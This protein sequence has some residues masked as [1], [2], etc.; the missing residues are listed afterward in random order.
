MGGYA[1][2]IDDD[3][4][5]QGIPVPMRDATTVLPS[6]P[7]V[8]MRNAKPI[9]TI[10]DQYAPIQP[11]PGSR[12]QPKPIPVDAPPMSPTEQSGVSMTMRAPN[13]GAE[14]E[15][16]I[17]AP[18]GRP[19][20]VGRVSGIE[21]TIDPSSGQYNTPDPTKPAVAS[22][23]SK[24][25]N[26]HNPILRVLGEIGA[27]T[28]RAL[29][30]V[31]T[32]VAPGVAAAI[33]GSTV[34]K[35]VEMARDEAQQ[36]REAKRA[37]EEATT[38]H[39]QAETGDA[40][41][42]TELTRRQ[43]DVVGDPKQGLTPEEVTIH[44][45]MTGEKGQPRINPQ[46]QQPYSYL[47]A[48][49]AVQQ[50]KQDS[51]PDKAV[52]PD[53]PEQQYID[54]YQ[55]LHPGAT[56]AEALKTYSAITQKPE[57]EP[58]QLMVVPGAAPNT[59]QV[60][61]VKPGMTISNQAA[62]PGEAATASRA[63][64]R[65]HDKA[66]VQPAE[67]VEKSYQMMNNAYQEYEAARKLGKDLPTGA[68][69]MVALSTHLATTFGNVKGARVTKDMIEEHLG[70]R[71]VSDSALVAMQKFT[72]GDALSPDQ[73]KAFHDLIAQ[74]RKLSWQTAAKE[75]DRKNIPID[76]LPP[77]LQNVAHQPGGA[78]TAPQG[79]SDEVYK[80]G[81]LIGH[82]VDHKFVGLDK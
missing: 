79:A 9:P 45:L 17:L 8:P 50:A 74:S 6:S 62:K 33:P 40:D 65:E 53:A 32:V 66:Y 69:S 3:P 63:A 44:D 16:P 71:S 24:A 80:D 13:V 34:N 31:G 54:E 7:Q 81:R 14:N 55:K 2:P 73:W 77:D 72:N 22:L 39:T 37:G 19:I 1:I 51:K 58:Q 48:Y 64:V 11:G 10:L 76:F 70:A 36:D 30:T 67:A 5:K 20:P 29:D 68:Q 47:D 56:V 52:K 26:I 49:Q 15:K 61:A 35:R 23:W 42:H 78:D 25:Q 27:G 38:E 43:A 12:T 75:A 28:A 60:I 4:L 57:R 21:G 59:Q 46:T 41:A 82:V 18:K